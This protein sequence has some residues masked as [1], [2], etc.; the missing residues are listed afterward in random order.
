L[1]ID[2]PDTER[3][4]RAAAH[5]W[6]RRGPHRAAAAVITAGRDRPD[7]G[8]GKDSL[9]HDVIDG[10]RLQLLRDLDPDGTPALLYAVITAFLRDAPTQLNAM[11]AAVLAGGEPR[12][13]QTAHQ[14]KGSAANPGAT[15]VRALCGQLEALARTGAEPAD[16]LLHQLQAELDR[17]ARA[18]SDALSGPT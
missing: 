6:P 17:A 9:P 12:L 16:E 18:L 14:L 7:P 3:I 13:A 8:D 5:R 1:A 15:R 4:D 2:D 10:A 11:R